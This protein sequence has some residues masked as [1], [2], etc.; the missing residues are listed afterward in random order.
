MAKRFLLPFLIILILVFILWAPWITQ[1]YAEKRAEEAFTTTWEGVADGCGFNC[2]GCG[3]EESR[4]T[5][6]GYLVE[7][8]YACGM[9]PE[10]SEQYHQHSSG[11]ISFLG[12]VHGFPEP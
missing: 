3:V 9:L 10:D 12:T 1:S 6:F 5:G 8:E 11:F 7:I 4:K 2:S